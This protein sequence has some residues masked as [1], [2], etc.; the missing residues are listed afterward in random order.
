MLHTNTF[1]ESSPAVLDLANTGAAYPM[2]HLLLPSLLL[3]VALNLQEGELPSEMF[4]KHNDDPY[5]DDEEE[6][7]EQERAPKA[8]KLLKPIDS[9]GV[10]MPLKLTSSLTGECKHM[11]CLMPIL[12][13]D[14]VSCLRC[15]WP[16]IA[17]PFSCKCISVCSL[18]LAWCA[19]LIC[20]LL[21]ATKALSHA[22]VALHGRQICSEPLPSLHWH[23]HFLSGL[24]NHFLES[25]NTT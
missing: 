22:C 2:L 13:P 9:A 25:T 23:T 18:L 1:T 12:D 8:A 17:L 19:L 4:P 14:S 10:R 15:C 7:Q 20:C 3:T 5:N 21:C 24:V 11:Q 16:T 6:E